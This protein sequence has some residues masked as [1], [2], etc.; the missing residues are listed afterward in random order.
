MSD[1]CVCSVPG[2]CTQCLT[3]VCVLCQVTLPNTC[4]QY[5]Q[6][7]DSSLAVE[8]QA[9][10]KN[11]PRVCIFEGTRYQV[12]DS[13]LPDINATC[14]TCSC[15]VRLSIFSTCSLLGEVGVGV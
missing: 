4:W 1:R 2:V 14:H 15:L 12:G 3:G 7:P 5:M 8:E 9:M 13:W 6:D 10:A 11:T